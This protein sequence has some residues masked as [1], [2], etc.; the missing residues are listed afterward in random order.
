MGYT[1]GEILREVNEKN[2]VKIV[3]EEICEKDTNSNIGT[4]PHYK[5]RIVWINVFIFSVYHISALYG[6]YLSYKEA[7]ILTSAFGLFVFWISTEGVTIGAH[8]LWTHRS[9]RA[10]PLLAIILMIFQTIAGQNSIWTW[11]RDHR[12]H[13]RYADTDADPHSA[14]RGFFFA[15]MGWLMSLK[16]PMVIKMGKNINME[17]LNADPIVMFQKKHYLPLYLLFSVCIPIAIPVYCWNES[18]IPSIFITYFARYVIELHVTWSVNS[19]AH[20]YGN[21]PFDKNILSVESNLV[22]FIT[23]GEGWHNY[24]HVFPWDYKTAELRSPLQ[25]STRII[26]ACARYGF[27]YDLKS[28]SSDMV[29]ARAERTGDETIKIRSKQT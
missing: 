3:A 28:V 19:I 9:Y 5:R 14:S 8:R 1:N 20:F 4:D 29:R 13:H 24:H 12:M 27:A 10:T 17:D 7:K 23:S 15:H 18:L 21:K 16:H 26:N 25:L 22:S 11:V 2:Y 6:I